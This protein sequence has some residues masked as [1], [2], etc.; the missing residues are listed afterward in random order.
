[1]C[2]ITAAASE[3]VTDHVKSS[4]TNLETIWT[5]NVL[6]VTLEN[7]GGHVSNGGGGSPLVFVQELPKSAENGVHQVMLLLSHFY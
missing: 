3:I 6:L 5:L 4:Q 2:E 1:M 7:V